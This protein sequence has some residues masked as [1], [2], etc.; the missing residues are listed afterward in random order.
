MND[1]EHKTAF[2]NGINIHYVTLGEGP[3]LLL[4]HGF[5]QSWH[6]WRHQI[7]PLSKHFKVVA[8]DLRGYGETDKPP[9]I[10]DYKGEILALDIKGLIEALGYQKAHVVGHDWGGSVAWRTAINHPDS[11]DRLVVINSP[12]PAAF[13]RAL[14]NDSKQRLKSWYMFFFQIP[15]LPEALI[16]FNLKNTLK[17][18]LKGTSKKG[19]FTDEDIEIYTKNFEKP[20]A[21][22]AALNYYRA[23]FRHRP[24]QTHKIISAPTLLI[25][26]ENDAVLGKGLT[27]NLEPLFNGPFRIQYIPK[28]SHWVNEEEPEILN[29]HLIQFLTAS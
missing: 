22:S 14:K 17:K 25:W 9:L 4:L 24:H 20:G 16:R 5:P 29:D 27:Y 23:A 12:H 18:I 10:E 7:L 19:T 26:G 8:P 21:I 15:Y 11:V 28:C 13:A 2:C 3:L 1:W 6:T